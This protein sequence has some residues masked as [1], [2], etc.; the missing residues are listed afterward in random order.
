MAPGSPV[1]QGEIYWVDIKPEHT[2][3]SEQYKRRPWVIVSKDALNSNR[4][5]IGVPLSTN[6]DKACAYNIKIPATE[7]LIDAGCQSEISDSVAL[8]L[9]IRALDKL[10]LGTRI[11]RLTDSAVISVGA[12][13]SYVLDL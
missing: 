1:V 7:I 5:V 10:R 4:V 8:T 6:L 2:V 12:G 11:G 3:G 13:I 9:Q